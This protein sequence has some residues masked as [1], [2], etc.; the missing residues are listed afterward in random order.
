MN[1]SKS[2]RSVIDFNW[3]S[4]S[5][6]TDDGTVVPSTNFLITSVSLI[7]FHF[8]PFHFISLMKL[9]SFSHF[10]SFSLLFSRCVC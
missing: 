6:V 5:A 8:I 7:S 4:V 10:H 1:H 2:L 9:R 3:R